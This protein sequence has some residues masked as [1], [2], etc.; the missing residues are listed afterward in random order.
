MNCKHTKLF[1]SSFCELQSTLAMTFTNQVGINLHRVAFMLLYHLTWI[2]FVF[3]SSRHLTQD[4]IWDIYLSSKIL[5]ILQFS[6]KT[7]LYV[8]CSRSRQGGCSKC[9]CCRERGASRRISHP[10]TGCTAPSY[11]GHTRDT[12]YLVL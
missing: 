11:I 9:I 12:V 5:V 2:H 1:Y 3:H 10:C 7:Q 8:T 4:F 6:N